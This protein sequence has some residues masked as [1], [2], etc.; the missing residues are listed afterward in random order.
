MLTTHLPGGLTAACQSLLLPA[1]NPTSL[2][3]HAAKVTGLAGK[4][5]CYTVIELGGARVARTRIDMDNN[6]PKWGER[7][8]IACAHDVD[9]VIVRVK[10]KDAIG[11]KTMGLVRAAAELPLECETSPVTPKTPAMG[12]VCLVERMTDT[13]KSRAL[14]HLPCAQ[15]SMCASP[16]LQEGTCI[17]TSS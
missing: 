10:D 17:A 15:L 5:D 13:V 12:R 16:Y 7:F 8:V 4:P 6:D 3:H 9:D 14:C 2:R 11:S 1:G